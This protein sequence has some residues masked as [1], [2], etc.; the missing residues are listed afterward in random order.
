MGVVYKARH[1]ELDRVVALKMI[2]AGVQ[3]G[4]KDRER[5]RREAAAVA[6]LHHPNIVQVFDIGDAGGRPYFALEYIEKGSLAKYLRS[7]P[8]PLPAILTLIET[9]ARA[10]AYA[11][12]CGIIHRDLK[13]ANILLGAKEKGRST[14]EDSC[15]IVLDSS[16]VPKITDFGLAKRLDAGG[17]ELHSEEVLGT[18]S[19]MAPEQAGA[20]KREIGPAT[21]VYALGAILYEMLTGRPPFKGTTSLD[22]LVQ[23]LHEEPVPPGRLRPKLPRDVDT[24]C[25]KCLEKD[26]ARRYVSASALADDLRR[27]R[28]G[29]PIEARP[30]S[31]LERGWKWVRR[32]PFPA[33]LVAGIILVTLLGMVGVTWQW[34]IAVREKIEQETQRQQARNALYFSRIAQSQLQWRVNDISAALRTLEDCVPRANDQHDRRGWEWYYLKSLYR[35]ELF[36]FSHPHFG[37]DGSVAYDPSGA[38]I[39]SVVCIGSKNEGEESELRLWDAVGGNLVH[40]QVFQVPFHRIAFHPDGKRLVLASTD[41]RILVWDTTTYQEVWQGTIANCRIAGVACSPDGKTVATAAIASASSAK[42]GEITLWD[43]ETGKRKQLRCDSEDCNFHCVGF[44]PTLPLLASGGEDNIVRLWNIVSGKEERSLYGHNSAVY[45][46]AFSPDGRRLVSAGNNGNLKIWILEQAKDKD[47][48]RGKRTPEEFPHGTIVPQN[49]TG[50][51]GAILALAFSPDSRS[52]AYA[53]TDKTVR[54]WDME[55]GVG[56]MVF[57]GHMGSV[58]SVQFSADGRRLVSCSPA[59]GEVKVWDLT[60]NPD[61]ST[62]VRTAGDLNFP[63]RDLVD[64]AFHEDGQHLVSVTVAGEL[65]VW[66]AISGLLHAQYS[67]PISADPIDLGGILAAF[68]PGGRSLA[69]RYHEDRRLVRIW[70]VDS[71]EELLTC[72]GHTLPVFCLFYSPDGRYLATCAC[73]EKTSGKPFEIK[74]WDAETGEHLSDIRGLGQILTVLFSPDGRWLAFGNDKLLRVFDWAANR[75]VVSPLMSHKS[76]VTAIAFN[77]DGTRIASAAIN[78]PE[79]LIWDCRQWESSPKVKRQPVKRLPAP[80]QLCDLTFS[81]DGQRLVGA[82][83]DLIKMWDVESGVEVLTLRGAPPRYGDPPF[84]A[85]IVFHTDGRRLAAANW[86]ESISVWDA[87]MPSNEEDRIEQE[88]ARR[89]GTDERAFFWH[90]EEAEYCVEHKLTYGAR[91]HL[92][93][94]SQAHLPPLLQDRMKR[95]STIMKRGNK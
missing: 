37:S 49:L 60:R 51:T 29:D 64:I 47:G 83:R 95:L 15:A 39:A 58:E 77:P 28:R 41:G 9:L 85:R 33:A 44:H 82:N 11:H 89:Q 40:S 45:G 10:V 1:L 8:Q 42:G 32:R 36:A 54:I 61:Y 66:D 79:I 34:R 71:G 86:N 17:M 23:V 30:V 80:T 53:G 93:R 14:K 73:D 6:R 81:P 76:K 75:E 52:F 67:L 3:A 20:N 35:S 7:E 26:P 68:R 65:Q 74:V 46:V 18:P 25:L 63:G 72:R 31:V 38:R 92:Q 62:L 84:N 90:L 12:Q 94:L 57:R 22:T 16:Y 13:P 27:C 70:N 88:T 24:I 4:P 87:P 91:F 50:R 56:T 78:D 2:L 21:D 5:F 55:F 19:Y 69:A 43:A 48:R 59:R